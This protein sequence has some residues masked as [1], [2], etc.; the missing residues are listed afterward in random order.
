MI[1]WGL[2]INCEEETQAAYKFAGADTTLVHI[3][4]LLS[5]KY[6][7]HDFQLIHF[8]GGFSFGDHLGAG[9]VLANRIRFKRT[10]SG[11]TFRDELIDFTKNGGFLF[12]ICNGFQILV[13]LGLLPY[14]ETHRSVSLVSNENGQFQDRWVQ[15]KFN[16]KSPLAGIWKEESIYLPIRHGEGRL[17]VRDDE[18]ARQIQDQNLIAMTYEDPN[19]NGSFANC[20]ALCDPSGRILG[21]MPHPEA[22]L[23]SFNHPQWCGRVREEGKG[24]GLKLFENLINYIGAA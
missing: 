23:S 18:T 9:R 6:S 3:N 16:S 15:C 13:A 14:E 11:K 10:A 1:L 19:P 8:P 7:V 2:G 5:E 21:M 4:E 20:A 17:L 24:Q 22:F 12:G